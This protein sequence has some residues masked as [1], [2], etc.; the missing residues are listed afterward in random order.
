MVDEILHPPRRDF[1]VY[2]I[3]RPGGDVCYIGKGH[4]GRWQQHVK[5]S[6]NRRL[7]RIY[8]K[9]GGDLP[10][11][12]VREGLT[13]KEA[14]ETEGQL[15][16]AIGRADLGSGP[17]VN[18]TDGGEGTV[19][20]IAPEDVRAK[21]SMARRGKKLTGQNLLN[22]RACLIA[23]NANEEHRA[24][25]SAGLIGRKKSPE[26]VAKIS[27]AQRGKKKWSPEARAEMSVTRRGR[28]CP[29]SPET[30]TKMIAVHVGRK[31]SPEIRARMSAGRL[32]AHAERV[33]AE[34]G[35]WLIDPGPE[36]HARVASYHENAQ[37]MANQSVEQMSLDL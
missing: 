10:V 3:F 4:G 27:A 19:G 11:I 16:A 7:S 35:P 1:Y 31:N 34:A 17:L 36:Y 14:F 18:L 21:M 5:R 6:C 8:A 9:A 12:K 30:R 28:K 29:W 15:I 22:V 20:W 13:E 2:A 37:R 33:R 26:H 32:Q 24:R 25:I 23:R